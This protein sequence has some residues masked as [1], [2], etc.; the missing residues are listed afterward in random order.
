MYIRFSNDV[1]QKN[2][3]REVLPAIMAMESHKCIEH[4]MRCKSHEPDPVEVCSVG[5][6]GQMFSSIPLDVCSSKCV[7]LV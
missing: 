3:V 1:S 6:G 4:D 5:S 7:Y 2:G